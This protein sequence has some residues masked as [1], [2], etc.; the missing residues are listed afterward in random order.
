[1]LND[2]CLGS[3][4]RART[5]EPRHENKDGRVKEIDIID[6]PGSQLKPDLTDLSTPIYLL[7]YYGTNVLLS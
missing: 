3:K 7:I 1:M 6:R 2:S 4:L 5:D